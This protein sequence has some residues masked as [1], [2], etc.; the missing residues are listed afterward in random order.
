MHCYEVNQ[1]I[2]C[3]VSEEVECRSVIKTYML[4]IP[5]TASVRGGKTKV[6]GQN[7]FTNT[8]SPLLPP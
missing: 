2:K 5:E 3:S 8:T 7:L 6:F 4:S 1:V